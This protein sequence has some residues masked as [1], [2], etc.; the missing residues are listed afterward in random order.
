MKSEKQNT[1]FIVISDNNYVKKIIKHFFPFFIILINH[2]T[3]FGEGKILQIDKIKN[4]MFR[5]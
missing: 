5:F 3:H 1:K 2:I 4:T